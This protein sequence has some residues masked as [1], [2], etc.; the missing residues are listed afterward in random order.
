MTD[1][2]MSTQQSHF[3][4]PSAAISLFSGSLTHRGHN[5]NTLS[6]VQEA[7]RS[8]LLPTSFLASSPPTTRQHG[9][10]RPRQRPGGPRRL[11]L[12]HLGLRTP[13]RPRLPGSRLTPASTAQVL[14]RRRRHHSRQ[15]LRHRRNHPRVPQGLTFSRGLRRRRCAADGAVL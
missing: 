4:N 8:C 1:P 9:F 15:R 5:C 7:K 12:R 3:Q 11:C 10:F 14:S 2:S 6:Q 13:R